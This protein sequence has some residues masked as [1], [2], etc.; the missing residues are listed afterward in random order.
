MLTRREQQD[1]EAFITAVKTS[2]K[3]FQDRPAQQTMI[4]AVS[5]T[6]DQC[7]HGA[8]TADTDGSNFLVCESGT[9][10][11]KTLGYAIPAIVMARS[12]GK[13]LILSS[14]TVALQSQLADK[15]LPFLH[16]HAPFEF[17]WAIVKGRCRYVCRAKLMALTDAAGQESLELGQGDAITDTEL[18]IGRLLKLATHLSSG[19]WDGDRDR[20]TIEVAPESL[21]ESH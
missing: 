3:D 19:Q 12:A 10:T 11:G 9:G 13:R 8:D 20:L 1:I 16:Q 14:S 5:E 21:A 2:L 7:R 4:R 15:D 17:R 6:L 18:D